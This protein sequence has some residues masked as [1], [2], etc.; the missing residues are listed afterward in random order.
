MNTLAESGTFLSSASHISAHSCTIFILRPH[1][2]TVHTQTHID[3]LKL[4]YNNSSAFAR[5]IDL[6]QNHTTQL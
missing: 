3:E 6:F 2:T 1:C 5:T 4:S